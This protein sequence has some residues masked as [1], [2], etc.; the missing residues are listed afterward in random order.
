MGEGRPGDQGSVRK[1][2]MRTAMVTGITGQDG[3]YLSRL[4]LRKGY[5][6]IGVVRADR[7]L[8]TG[9]LDHLGITDSLEFR[10]CN[11]LDKAQVADLLGREEPDEVYN[12]AAQSSVGR[13]FKN[14]IETIEFNT[15][16]LL[17]LLESIKVQGNGTRIYQA[18]SSEMYGLVKDLPVT[19][20]TPMHPRS[21]YAVSK[22]AAHWTAVNY[23]ESYG[24]FACCGILFNH[25][26]FLRE[27]SFFVKKVVSSAVKIEHGEQDVLRVGNL[28]LRRDMGYGP[29]YTEAMYQMMQRP[30]PSDYIICSGRSIGLSEIVEHVFSRLGLD[31]SALVQDQGL[32]R[33]ADIEDIYGDSSKARRE[34][35]WDYDMDF[36]AVLDMLIDEEEAAWARDNGDSTGRSL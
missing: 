9:T 34:L 20:A 25:E 32:H 29:R 22:A 31:H 23:R 7:P 28:D 35:A 3:A 5:Q 17:N 19:E 12:L 18:S 2:A 14:P 15:I 27:H 24:L 30:Q 36:R 6:V 13:S 26:S 10:P 8:R 16:S 21:P 33:P 11:L 1:G 4:L